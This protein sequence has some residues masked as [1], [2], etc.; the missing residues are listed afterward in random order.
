MKNLSGLTT[1]GC[2]GKGGNGVAEFIP[3][4]NPERI[5]L[6]SRLIMVF[7]RGWYFEINVPLSNYID[8][9]TTNGAQHCKEWHCHA[10]PVTNGG[11]GMGIGI[12]WPP[13]LLSLPH[14]YPLWFQVLYHRRGLVAWLGWKRGGL[15]GGSRCHV[16]ELYHRFLRLRRASGPYLAQSLGS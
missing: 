16:R 7:N 9:V 8:W 6:D 14:F 3:S 5:V 1:Q 10:L 13:L 11:M 15:G 12:Q 4:E 2:A